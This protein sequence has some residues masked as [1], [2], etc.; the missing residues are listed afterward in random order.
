MLLAYHKPE[1]PKRLQM[2]CACSGAHHY[3]HFGSGSGPVFFGAGYASQSDWWRIG[4][5]ISVINLIIWMGIGMWW[6]KLIGLW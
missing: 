2:T 5:L 3:R 4:F 1:D 6:W